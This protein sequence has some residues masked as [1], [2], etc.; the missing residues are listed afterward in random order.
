MDADRPRCVL[1]EASINAHKRRAPPKKMS[2]GTMAPQ[3]IQRQNQT[4]ASRFRNWAMSL[5]NETSVALAQMQSARWKKQADALAAVVTYQGV[6][7]RRQEGRMSVELALGWVVMLQ[8]NGH[9]APFNLIVYGTPRVPR[10]AHIPSAVLPKTSKTKKKSASRKKKKKEKNNEQGTPFIPWKLLPPN[11][12]IADLCSLIY[13]N[14]KKY[15]RGV[16][17]N[18]ESFVATVL[19]KVPTWDPND[20]ARIFMALSPLPPDAAIAAMN[21]TLGLTNTAGNNDNM[22]NTISGHAGLNDHD[23]M[24]L[25]EP[26]RALAESS[27]ISRQADLPGSASANLHLSAVANLHEVAGSQTGTEEMEG[28][29]DGS[30]DATHQEQPCSLAMV[31][32]KD[33]EPDYCDICHKDM[34]L[35]LND[36]L[37]ICKSCGRECYC[38][39][40][41]HRLPKHEWNLCR[42]CL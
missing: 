4:N 8:Q 22:P 26:K 16:P 20:I 9:T 13:V 14:R 37:V 34:A 15:K 30:V 18:R 31:Q 39:G 6:E 25:D 41:E 28:G 40:C 1:V 10:I 23:G 42:T 21:G 33:T 3:T 12:T 29:S 35:A 24:S 11:P 36:C 19:Q 17:Y 27:Q 5:R 32:D 38:L 2:S 7:R